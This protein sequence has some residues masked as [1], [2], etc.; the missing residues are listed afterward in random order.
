M[1]ASSLKLLKRL[2]SAAVV[3]AIAATPTISTSECPMEKKKPT[4][5]GRLF[6]CTKLA[7]DIVDRRDGVGIDR[8]A[9][10]EGIGR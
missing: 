3:R 6:S 1:P 10:A 2:P 4:A 8:V 7:R 5:M 9:E